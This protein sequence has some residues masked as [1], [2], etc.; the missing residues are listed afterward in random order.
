MLHTRMGEAGIEGRWSGRSLR[1]GF[2]STAADLDLRLEDIAR[3]S[4]HATLDSLIR[5]IQSDDPWR[6]NPTASMGL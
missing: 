6:H 5:Y 1:R 3:A 4:R 2:I